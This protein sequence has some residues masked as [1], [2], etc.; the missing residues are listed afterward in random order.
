MPVPVNNESLFSQGRTASCIGG[1]ALISLLAFEAIAVAA[2]MPAVATA[3][4]GLDF[5]AIAFGGTLA[6]SVVGMAL[7]GEIC[8]RYGAARSAWLGL[9]AFIAGL[10]AAGAASDMYT[11]VL[12]RLMQGLG[13]GL[14]GVAIYVG[15]SRAVPPALH[16]K[17]FAMFAGAWVVP[18]LIGPGIAAGL[19]HAFGWRAVF[20]AV[21]AVA[22]VAGALLLPALSR[23]AAPAG[24]DKPM[25]WR[26]LGW[27]LLAAGGALTLHGSSHLPQPE[28]IPPVLAIGFAVAVFAARRLLPAGSLRAAEGLPAVV[29]MRGLIAAAFFASE[30]FVPLIL[31]TR[32]RWSLAEAGLALT[33]GALMWSV[34]SATQA[35][36]RA[37]AARRRGLTAGFV[38]MAVGLSV[39]LVAAGLSLHPAWVVAGWA[40]NGLG[41][42]LSFPMLSVLTMKLS[43][44]DEQ[45]SNAS[46]LQL[47]DA[48]SS[49]IALALAGMLMHALAR[50]AAP[51]DAQPILALSA[52]L[53]LAGAWVSPRAF[54]ATVRHPSRSGPQQDGA[55]SGA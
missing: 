2:A 20:L 50:P 33:A 10:L 43:R 6:T 8:D 7:G 9:A 16:P 11:L 21:A 41:I 13:S 42:G 29:A 39:A 4:G 31:T 53:A 34:G 5:Y 18:A 49:S 26:R 22:P 30:A 46:A 55:G 38:A 1:I 36:L 25:R 17:L 45:G 27:S 24:A 35:R 19:V 51:P 14:L 3:L 54:H 52:L 12:G 32:Y 48:L 37:E 28:W 15:M 44:P 47:S 23:Q 40:L